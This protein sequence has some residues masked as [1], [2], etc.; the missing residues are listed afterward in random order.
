M[1]EL[2]IK[3]KNV[4]ERPSVISVKRY[5]EMKIELENDTKPKI[6]PIFKLNDPKITEM[7]N[8]LLNFLKRYVLGQESVHETAMIFSHR[9]RMEVSE[10]ASTT[11]LLTKRQ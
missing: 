2:I 10:C 7:K 9:K 6:G 1:K 11:D 3:Y 4:F 5:I 8:K